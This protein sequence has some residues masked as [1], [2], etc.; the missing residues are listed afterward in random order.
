MEKLKT[1]NSVK[2]ILLNSKNELL[3]LSTDDKSI[4]NKDG[5]Y[6]GKFWQLVGGKIEEGETPIEAAK[7]ELFEETGLSE[8][9]VTFGDVVWKG[10]LDLNMKGSMTHINQ[11]FIYAKT[12]KENVT[13][14]NLTDEEKS[15]IKSLEWLSLEK[16]RN[17]DDIIYPVVLPEYLPNI[18]IGNFPKKTLI[19]DL[20]RQPKKA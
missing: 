20:S 12:N 17:S 19:I 6:N 16:I 8:E 4:K 10:E 7:R 2:I 11:C 3:L 5:R 13:L 14:K 15:V 1:R 18:I 9:D